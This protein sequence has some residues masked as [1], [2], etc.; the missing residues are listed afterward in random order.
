MRSLIKKFK[1]KYLIIFF[2][3]NLSLL[4][5]IYTYN[6]VLQYKIIKKVEYNNFNIEKEHSESANSKIKDVDISFSIKIEKKNNIS[7]IFN[8]GTKANPLTMRLVKPS[9][10]QINYIPQG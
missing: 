1:K 7:N 3:L 8:F 4:W 10:L 2:L 5:T 6:D 9:L